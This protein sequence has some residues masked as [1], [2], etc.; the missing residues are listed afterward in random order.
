MDQSA[1]VRKLEMLVI[2]IR[3][4][5]VGLEIPRWLT[6]NPEINWATSP[7][8]DLRIPCGEREVCWPGI[9]GKY[10]GGKNGEYSNVLLQ[11]SGGSTLTPNQKLQ[12]QMDPRGYTRDRG[13]DCPT[14]D[15][16]LHEPTRFDNMSGVDETIQIVTRWTGECSGLLG[17]MMPVSF[18]KH[19]VQ[20][21]TS[22]LT[23]G[24]VNRCLQWIWGQIRNL[25]RV[26]WNR[27]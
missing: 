22:N 14:P 16:E 4:Y 13:A 9:I 24:G 6:R 26:Y 10:Y 21:K 8:S 12:F 20:I 18:V 2:L 1:T 25:A 27:C 7:L 11:V 17:V 5:H 19:P 15:I 3:L 23:T